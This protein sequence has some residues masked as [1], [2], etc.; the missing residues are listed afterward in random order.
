MPRKDGRSSCPRSVQIT[1]L[2]YTS[3]YFSPSTTIRHSTTIWLYL[4]RAYDRPSRNKIPSTVCYRLR[5]VYGGTRQTILLASESAR[6]NSSESWNLTFALI[7]L[8]QAELRLGPLFVMVCMPSRSAS[9]RETP[10]ESRQRKQDKDIDAARCDNCHPSIFV[11][12]PRRTRTC[13][14]PPHQVKWASDTRPS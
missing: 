11:C 2:P 7:G 3:L 14:P 4:Y 9:H 13:L 10:L 8:T 5:V 12:T 1:K 6:C